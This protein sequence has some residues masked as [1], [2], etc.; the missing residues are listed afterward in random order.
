MRP[1]QLRSNAVLLVVVAAGALLRASAQPSY[2]CQCHDLLWSPVQQADPNMTHWHGVLAAEVAR[3]DRMDNSQVWRTRLCPSYPYFKR[4]C[5]A[6]MRSNTSS[7][8]CSGPALLEQRVTLG[9]ARAHLP[10]ARG[11]A[12]TL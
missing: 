5:S 1:R 12:S 9:L 8:S 2:L 10:A 3:N 6:A 4:Q 11:C 7:R